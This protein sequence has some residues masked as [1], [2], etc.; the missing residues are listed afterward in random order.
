MPPTTIVRTCPSLQD[1]DAAA[2]A[3]FS[4]LDNLL[5]IAATLQP[6]PTKWEPPLGAL[7]AAMRE[8]PEMKRLRRLVGDGT[9]AVNDL[10][11][12]DERATLHHLSGDIEDLVNAA[13]AVG[14]SLG[15]SCSRAAVATRAV[16]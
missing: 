2:Y 11:A 16:A 4:A 3:T 9:E 15:L 13:A 14:F 5:S 1:L 10:L 6:D 8:S 12:E 7:G